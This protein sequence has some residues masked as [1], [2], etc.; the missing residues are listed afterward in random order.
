MNIKGYFFN[1]FF[2]FTS[3]YSDSFLDWS[4]FTKLRYDGSFSFTLLW[5]EISAGIAATDSELITRLLT[6]IQFWAIYDAP[7][8][9]FFRKINFFFFALNCVRIRINFSLHFFF[10][11]HFQCFYHFK[12]NKQI[13][14]VLFLK[15]LHL[16]MGCLTNILHGKAANLLVGEL[17][18]DVAD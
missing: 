3:C 17:D 11:C 2:F 1:C 10:Q 12:K 15:V 13:L 9:G 5:N 14:R 16:P 7:F 18:C 8:T 6:S 4:K